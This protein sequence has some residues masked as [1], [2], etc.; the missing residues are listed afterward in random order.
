MCFALFLSLISA[1]AL[2]EDSEWKT[3]WDSTLYGYASGTTLRGDSVVNP[4]NYIARLAQ[5]SNI[6]EARSDFKAELD[7]LQ[8]NA[9]PILL[10]Q[11]NHNSFGDGN[12]SEAYFSQWQM[13]WKTNET[14]ALSAG[15]E[16]L[17]W[18]P[19]QFRSP[20]NPF[21][22]NNG[23]SNP[24]SELSGMDTLRLAWSSDVRTSVYVARIYDSGYGH[25]EPDP[26]SNS[27]LVKADWRGDES[28]AGVALA[29]QEQRS[30]FFG[31]HA[32]RT[33]EDA[34]LLYS[35][36]GSYTLPNLLRSPTDV[37]QPFIVEAESSRRTDELVGAAYTF[38]S[39]HTLTAEYLHYDHGYSAAES[40]AYFAR[41]ASAARIFSTGNS[42][43]VLSA[44]LTSAPPLLGRDYVYLVW[45]T[46]LM[47]S[48]GFSRMMY[49]HNLTDSS[50]ELSGY[51]EYT[52][53]PHIS[54]FGLASL[55][56]GA[57]QRELSRLYDKMLTLGVKVA[58]P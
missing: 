29:K 24:M 13:R 53:T 45:Q 26:W 58:L 27:W 1:T 12:N 19:A 14:L 40:S 48:A 33:V 31:A 6:V 32:Q 39:G 49:T 9:R 8:I 41:A 10:A 28:A 25:A 55:T 36:V 34:W 43:S 21:Y 54:A 22:F 7:V 20:S 50:D 51:S 18:G 38:E 52:I 16:L 44:A 15:R 4:G 23:R 17:N 56:H 11:Q 30:L 42:I 5:R 2:A 47:E 57:A 35:E 46:N 3:S 37:N